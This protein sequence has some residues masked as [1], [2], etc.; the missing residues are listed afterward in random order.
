MDETTQ[1]NLGPNRRKLLAEE[2]R[3]RRSEFP[4]L[5]ERPGLWEELCAAI[6]NGPRGL[7]EKLFK[8]FLQ[9]HEQRFEGQVRTWQADAEVRWARLKKMQQELLEAETKLRE[10]EK[11][12]EE[13][14]ASAGAELLRSI[15]FDDAPSEGVAEDLR[16]M[17]RGEDG[18]VSPCSAI[19][20][21]RELLP[22]QPE[23]MT[24][25][26]TTPGASDRMNQVNGGE[27][28]ENVEDFKALKPWV[29]RDH[30]CMG[31][32]KMVV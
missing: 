18:S 19:S 4:P 30:T 15:S 25:A 29:T 21:E 20:W 27:N 5:P 10:A 7:E 17:Q 13:E 11:I 24:V 32:Y 31:P 22:E 3:R 14:D 28:E 26:K 2:L 6:E 1:T 23:A 9:F 12:M 8:E 16:N